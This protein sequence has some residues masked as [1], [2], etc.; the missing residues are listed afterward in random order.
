MRKNK[1]GFVITEVLIIST[2]V[3]GL[4]IFM[5]AQFKN[6]NRN[7]QYSFKYDT[8]Q[9]MYLTNNI[10]NYINDGSYDL[11][12]ENLNNSGIGYLD[13]TSC[14]VYDFTTSNYCQILFEK[15]NVE[16]ILFTKEDLIELKT[17][18]YNLEESMKEYIKNIK[19][20]NLQNDYRIIVKYKDQT[21]ATMRFNKGNTYI[22]NGIF[23]HLDAIN[24]TGGGHSNEIAHWEDLS[25]NNNYAILYNNPNWNANSLV[26]NGNNY[27]QI[28]NTSNIDFINGFT[29]QLRLKIVQE[30]ENNDKENFHL[31]SN[32]ENSGVML[33]YSKTNKTITPTIYI[34]ND[35]G[36]EQISISNNKKIEY[37]KYYTVTVTYD[38]NLLKLYIDGELIDQVEKIGKIVSSHLPL[39]L[40]TF[41]TNNM[42][43]INGYA[44]M[45]IQILLMY[46]RALSNYE[47]LKNYQIDESRF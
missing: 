19:T 39:S 26:F 44:N 21:F 7:Y 18:M 24:N 37:G 14:S 45:E 28:N 32:S 41:P 29:Y 34:D 33:T 36:I 40:G 46:N 2:V 30:I 35:I 38:N 25:G 5:Y 3:M 10:V 23:A 13:I 4:L 22:N 6:I 8:V 31:F 11:L 17:N 20:S 47:V 15:S 12:V 42:N 9:S 27:A 1:K 16:Q 43:I